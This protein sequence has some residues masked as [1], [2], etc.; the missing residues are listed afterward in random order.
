MTTTPRQWITALAAL[1]VPA[2]AQGQRGAPPP[3]HPVPILTVQ[4]LRSLDAEIEAARA[5]WGVPGLAIAIVQGD[6]VILARGYGVKE[7]GK[8]DKVDENTLFAIGS[9][10]KSMT[11]T[12]ISMLVDEGTMRYDDP[13]WEYLP[14]FRVADPY[15]SREATIR[16][17]LSHRTGLENATAVWYGAPLTRAQ[18]IDR[19]RF[20]KQDAS[21]RSRFLYNN[22]M[23]MTAGEAA[24]VAA[25]KPWEELVRERLFTPLGMTSS[26]SNPQELTP[27]SNVATPHVDFGGKLSPIAHR[28]T[29]NIAP[30]GGEYS[31]ARDMAQYLR[32]QLGNGSYRGKRI[33]SP[34][35]MAQMRSVITS[36]GTPV[37]LSDSGTT[38]M[39]Y[40]LGWFTEY[41]RGHRL[42]RHGGA[43]DGMLTEMMF[44]PEDQIGVVVLTNMSP[45]TM[46]TALTRHIFDIALGLPQREWNA[47]AFARAK[48]QETQAA[49]RLRTIEARRAQNAPPSL[50]LASYAGT[51]TDSLNGDVTIAVENG[52]LMLRFHPTVTARLVPWQYDAFR[53]DWRAPSA[54]SSPASFATFMLD[55]TGQPTEVR[56]DGLGTFTASRAA[57]GQDRGANRSS[58]PSTSTRP[59]SRSASR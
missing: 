15:V 28:D 30:A 20:L 29:R 32:F 13:V 52:T 59:S 44:L 25:G 40:G 23:L 6:S 38:A 37:V 21:F 26:L 47:Q 49:E 48:A 27:G 12:T 9:S 8:A 11:A 4:Q 7:L 34:E 41:Y 43:I 42:L 19:M 5:Q 17:L 3:T 22:L 16:D 51:Y 14:N 35:S 45:H 18:L 33:V 54:L 56:I 31:S 53:V 39:G 2:I 50:P 55:A 36:N 1:L 57:G 10:G 24:A 58:G 46:H